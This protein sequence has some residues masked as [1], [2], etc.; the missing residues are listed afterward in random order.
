VR[1]Q[2]DAQSAGTFSVITRS[3][4]VDFQGGA[5]EL[6][7]YL[8][9]QDVSGNAGLWLRQDADGQMLAL[10]NMQSQQ[11]KG[12]HDWAQY[13]ITLPINP[14]AQQ[15]FFGVLVSGTGTLWADDLELLV[16]GKPIAEASPMPVKPGLPA[17]HEFDSGSRI[18]LNGL[19]PMQVSN[20]VTLAQVWGLL[21]YHHPAVTSGQRHWDYDLL[22]I[23]PAVLGAPDRAHANDAL[24]AWIEKLGPLPPCGPCVP[25]PSGDLNIKPVLGWFHDR[26]MLGGPLSERLE[27]I[28]A[29]RTGKQFYVSTVPG[30]GNPSFDHELAYSQ[31]TFPDS[32]YQ[33]LALF[34]WWNILQYWAPNRDTAGQNW[35]AVLANFIPQLALAKD[36]TAYQLALFEL[37]A[38]AN[39]THANLWSS[40]AAR[41]PV[42]ECALPVTL[43]F[44]GDKPIVYRLDSVDSA[45]QPGDILDTLD[46]TSIQLLVGKWAVY[47]ADSNDAARQ[48]DLAA[49]VTRGVCGPVSVKITR[50]GL[51]IQI[52][53]TR[54]QLKQTFVTHDQPGATF[55]L[56]SPQIAYIKLS[57][58]KAAD[59]PTYFDKAKN[60]K[61]LIVDI[62]NYPS[63]FM[64][65]AMGA[66]LA[67]KPTPFVA[68]TFADLANPGTFHFGDGPNISPGPVH[69]S[70]RVAVLV[71]ETSQ[72]QAEYTAMALRA[73][74]NAVV[75]GS[76]TAGADGNVSSISLP[77]HLS[78]MISGLGV[79]YPDHRP[80][81][82]IGIV[83]DV[84]VRPTIQG[85]A[86]GRDEVLETA[87]HVIEDSK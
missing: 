14:Q 37:I 69:Y 40:L 32:G 73:M 8:R 48:R 56:L 30:V 63:E 61:G 60:T 46:D 24:L 23:L 47:Y 2:R 72:S 66:Y 43:R 19:T 34:R 62:R 42:G 50:S 55:R 82:R 31:I 29:D 52:P 25:A 20:L 58:I 51:P 4:P 15:L 54:T 49:K 68:F 84:I 70:G 79:F 41:P 76:T 12:T 87:M 27:S 6:R 83:P 44:V 80:T 67:T 77:G 81:Q 22:R 10:E 39:D 45:F 35:P 75:V 71:D 28:Y 1:L 16:D 18:V 59:L 53:A 65:F 7:G 21:K 26:S 9:L 38:K 5:V 78:T 36:K 17:D 74:P 3:L 85:I 11:V 86:A 33:L 64:P 13:R 57:S